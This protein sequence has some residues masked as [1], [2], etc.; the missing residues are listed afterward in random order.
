MSRAPRPDPR[1][2]V[3]RRPPPTLPLHPDAEVRRAALIRLTSSPDWQIFVD[4]FKAKEFEAFF[5]GG[6]REPGAL[7]VMEGRRTFIR[8]LEGLAKRVTDDD[9]SDQRE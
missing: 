8:E 4:H 9:R 3:T 7:L 6:I 1:A 2:P 5:E